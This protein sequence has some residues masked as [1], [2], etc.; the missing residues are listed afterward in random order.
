MPS[1]DAMQPEVMNKGDFR[2][3]CKG[4]LLEAREKVLRPKWKIQLKRYPPKPTRG[5][6]KPGSCDSPIENKGLWGQ[7]CRLGFHIVLMRSVKARVKLLLSGRTP[8]I[9]GGHDK[10]VTCPERL[11]CRGLA[12]LVTSSKHL[13]KAPLTQSLPQ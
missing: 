2:S 7:L 4:Q 10:S 5:F 3:F 13:I 1:V 11:K 12:N 6:R 8:Y 9:Y